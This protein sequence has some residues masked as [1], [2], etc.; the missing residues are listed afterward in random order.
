[1]RA[2]RPYILEYVL[3][4]DAEQLDELEYR[5]AELLEEPWDQETGRPRELTL[6]EA[7]IVT[8]G[9]V[10]RTTS[11]P[12]ARTVVRAV[13]RR[14]REPGDPPVG[15]P[16]YQQCVEHPSRPPHRQEMRARQPCRPSLDPGSILA[17][18]EATPGTGASVVVAHPPQVF[19]GFQKSVSGSDQPSR[20]KAS[21]GL[22]FLFN[23][24][25]LVPLR[26]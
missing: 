24:F 14:G 1:M 19:V 4:L 3:G 5:V 20:T 25:V 7:L 26:D 21:P 16:E 6:R 17:R 12:A 23:L 18:P 2:P 8:C 13:G 15:H 22:S 10:R 11:A 9:Y